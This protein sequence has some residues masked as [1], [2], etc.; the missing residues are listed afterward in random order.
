[1]N[2]QV[3]E[4]P[5]LPRRSSR[6]ALSEINDASKGQTTPNKNSN[7]E[8]LLVIQ[9]GPRK[10]PITWSP[11]E[12]DRSKLLAPPRE[13]TPE[14]ATVHKLDINPR[15]RKRL[16]M[17]PEKNPSQELGYFIAKRLKSFSCI[18]KLKKC[19]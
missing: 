18:E 16:I 1:M 8:E 17:T 15:L 10:K 12:Y 9:R 11:V 14:P 13:T 2:E 7:V 4:E 6:L 5:N 19:T 3:Q